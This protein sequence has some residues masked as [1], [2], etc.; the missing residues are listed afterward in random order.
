MDKELT[1]RQEDREKRRVERA[2]QI[3]SLN[4][5]LVKDTAIMANTP[6]G[7]TFLK[8]LFNVCGANLPNT[9]IKEGEIQVQA[10]LHNEAVRG[11]WLKI[12]ENI[13]PRILFEIEIASTGEKEDDIS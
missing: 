5:T 10:T 6:E 12:R 13:P 9:V 11:V 4:N 2:Q 3:R 1:T 8:H 7:F